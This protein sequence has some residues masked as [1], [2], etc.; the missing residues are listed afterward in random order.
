MGGRRREAQPSRE[1]RLRRELSSDTLLALG[2]PGVLCG[3]PCPPKQCRSVIRGIE[4]ARG[5]DGGPTIRAFAE[6]PGRNVRATIANRRPAPDF[7][8]GDELIDIGTDCNRRHFPSTAPG[9]QRFRRYSDEMRQLR[10][11]QNGTLGKRLGGVRTA[12]WLGISGP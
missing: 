8:P 1:L 5:K 4:G 6:S 12:G 3:L 7:Q 2:I 9:P 10:L 11:G